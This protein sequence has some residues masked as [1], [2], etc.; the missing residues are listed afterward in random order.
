MKCNVFWQK[1]QTNQH[2]LNCYSGIARLIKLP[3]VL[4]KA[5]GSLSDLSNNL[6]IDLNTWGKDTSRDVQTYSEKLK[7]SLKEERHHQQA[8]LKSDLAVAPSIGLASLSIGL[9][10]TVKG[11]IYA[12][13]AISAAGSAGLDLVAG[14]IGYALIATAMDIAKTNAAVLAYN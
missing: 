3:K 4:I 11:I 5:I 6:M 12:L 1:N 10:G 14:S 7:Q 13:K 9:F 8:K 2:L